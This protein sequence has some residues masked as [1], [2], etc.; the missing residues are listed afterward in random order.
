[1]EEGMQM[2]EGLP[3]TRTRVINIGLSL[4]LNRAL[5]SAE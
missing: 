4:N 2:E 5:T 1:M 3:D